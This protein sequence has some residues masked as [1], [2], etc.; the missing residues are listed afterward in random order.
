MS[1]RQIVKIL[2]L[3]QTGKKLV[4]IVIIRIIQN[5]TDLNESCMFN[6]EVY[7]VI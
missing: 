5:V 2:L 7:L 3:Y 4:H 6:S 1:H